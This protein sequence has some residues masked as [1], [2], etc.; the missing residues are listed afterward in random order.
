MGQWRHLLRY[1]SFDCEYL[2]ASLKFTYY[3][4]IRDTVKHKIGSRNE[5]EKEYTNGYILIAFEN[6][7]GKKEVGVVNRTVLCY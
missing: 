3:A 2:T 1:C 6:F 5:G 4:L 7:R